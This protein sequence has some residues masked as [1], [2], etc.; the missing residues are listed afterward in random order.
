MPMEILEWKSPYEKLFGQPPVY[1]H[2]KVI[3][4]LCYAV[5]TVPQID[6]F[7]NRGIKCVLLGYPMNQKGYKLYNLQTQVVFNSR[8]VVFKEDVFTFKDSKKPEGSF[9]VHHFPS[10]GDDF[11]P[12][13]N[14]RHL[15]LDPAVVILNTPIPPEPDNE[16]SAPTG[17]K[18]GPYYPLFALTDFLGILQQLIAFLANV[19]TQ[20]EPTRYQQS[21]QNLGWVEVIKKELEALE[22]NNTWTLTKFPSR[23][24][25]ITF[26][27]VYKTKFKPT[28]II[29]RL[30]ARLVVRGFNQKE[31]L[32]YKHTFSPIARLATVRVLI[33][34][35][36]AKQ[37]PLHQL[38]INNAFL[39]EYINEEIYM[40]P[41][42]GYTKAKPG[43]VYK[44][45]KS[46]YGLKQASRQWNQELTRFL[47][48]KGYEQSK[49]DYYLFVKV[50]GDLFKAALV[51][52]DDVLITSNTLI[53]I[54]SLKKSLD[55]KFTIKDL[56]L[57]KY[58]IVRS[59]ILAMDPLLTVNKANYIVQQ[60]EKQKQVTN[61]V[62]E[63][64]AFFA[65][66]NNKNNSNGRR[67][68]NKGNMNEIKGETKNEIYFKKVC[69]NYSQE[70]YLFEQCFERLGYP[71]WYKGKKA[72]KNNRLATHVNS[73]F[74]EHFSG[75]TSFDIGYENEGRSFM[76]DEIA[77]S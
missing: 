46:L 60:I 72:K 77:S 64:T 28:S 19:F 3:G 76:V 65:N 44:L 62:F 38:D 4:C 58:F 22:R 48:E 1:D 13:T 34:I 41:P 40:L 24:K 15:P 55:D 67:E 47:V 68:N 18:S 25:A 21:I 56:G 50:Q 61:H 37:W 39:H 52:V 45:N 27:W 31:G 6:K 33:A 2:L 7:D 57:A 10:F 73:G 51:Y 43:Q 42:E 5:V 29:E 30:K 16:N 54:D 49:Q 17:T 26:K 69:T 11:Y 12:E 74:D 23:H 14:Q 8:D 66:I 35:A 53:E 70:G 36:T 20:P 63:P 75:E 59:Q 71:N 32:D 9:F